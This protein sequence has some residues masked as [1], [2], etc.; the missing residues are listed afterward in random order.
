M[1][2]WFDKITACDPGDYVQIMGVGLLV[3]GFR[4]ELEQAS[5]NFNFIQRAFWVSPYT[6]PYWEAGEYFEKQ[7]KVFDSE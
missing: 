7:K 6:M 5:L 3:K 4:P 1:D 2:R